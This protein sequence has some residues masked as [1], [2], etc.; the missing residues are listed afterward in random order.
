MERTRLS[1][2]EPVCSLAASRDLRAIGASQ[3]AL[4]FVLLPSALTYKSE[5]ARSKKGQNK[6]GGIARGMSATQFMTVSGIM[7]FEGSEDPPHT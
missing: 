4:R 7:F 3:K 5:R 1:F 6:S 2:S